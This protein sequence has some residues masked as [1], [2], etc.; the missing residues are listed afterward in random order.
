MPNRLL[1]KS[2][3]NPEVPPW[4]AAVVLLLVLDISV[5]AAAFYLAYYLR[6]ESGVL[7]YALNSPLASYFLLFIY[8][9]PIFLTIFYCC[10]LYDHHELFYGTS[11]Y[12]QV[13]KGVGF[14]VLGII[15]VSFFVHGPPPSRGWL[16]FFWVCGTILVGI[17]RFS[18]R[19]LV[20]PMLRSKRRSER[21]MI[22]GANE[23]ATA[24]TRRLM[25]TGHL[26]VV[27]FLDDFSPVGE[28][29]LNGLKIK[30]SPVDFEEIA[31]REGVTKLILVPGAAGWETTREILS[32]A[33][34]GNGLTILVAP[35]LSELFS[36]S[37]RV[38][39]VGY[40]PFLRFRPG[41]SGG[42][43]SVFKGIIDWSLSLL[44][45]LS[46]LPVMLILGVWIWY[47][48]GKPIFESEAVLGRY[49]RPVS[50]YKFHLPGIRRHRSFYVPGE[51]GESYGSYRSAL[52][53]LL[54]K[55]GLD[56][57]PNFINVLKGQISLVGPRPL[58]AE[59]TNKY[60]IWLPNLQSVKPGITGP[61]AIEQI[62]N[63][64]QEISTTLA[65]VQTWTPWKDLQIFILTVLYLLQKGLRVPKSLVHSFGKDGEK[66]EIFM[67]ATRRN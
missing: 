67:P 7:P 33:T 59:E 31:R 16:F 24:I 55:S 36:A 44:I 46:F 47:R 20:R 4:R 25:E 34:K 21:V 50:L 42:L 9:L 29:V 58:R 10:H 12:V 40:V 2:V 61:W 39:Y 17:G 37:L 32:T 18:A 1:T 41:Y 43:N 54:I 5:L 27:G 62:N 3:K 49:G 53:G 60:G 57:L 19:R 65:Y 11:E 28:E 38:S 51:P 14:G 6:M 56:R 30:G 35:G 22:V 8:S 15:S 66:R 13:V 23:E 64:Q 26:E 45:L 52:E 48:Q 63:L